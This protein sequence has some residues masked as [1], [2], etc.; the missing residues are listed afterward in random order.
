MHYAKEQQY[1]LHYDAALSTNHIATTMARHVTM[2]LYLSDV[3]AGGESESTPR[4]ADCARFDRLLL[5]TPAWTAALLPLAGDGLAA[6]GCE[7]CEF[8]PSSSTDWREDQCI[9][10]VKPKMAEMLSDC[11]SPANTGVVAKPQRGRLVLWY[12]YHADGTFDPSTIVSRTSS[13]C[14]FE[15]HFPARSRCSYVTVVLMSN[16]RSS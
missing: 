6:H 16:I 9:G 8:H 2:L 4:S 1:K 7:R 11:A 10:C 14:T 5:I 13:P 3:E 12:N 15:R